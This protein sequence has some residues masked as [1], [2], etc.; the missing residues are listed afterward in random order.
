MVSL[1][2]YHLFRDPE[3]SC[4]QCQVACL[5]EEDRTWLKAHGWKESIESLWF[6]MND[7]NLPPDC[8]FYEAP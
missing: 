6:R 5:T 2:P 4:E 3:C 1:G 7:G 8:P